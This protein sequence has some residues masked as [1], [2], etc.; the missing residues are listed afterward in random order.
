M[1]ATAKQLEPFAVP[2]GLRGTLFRLPLAELL[3]ALQGGS[4]TGIVALANGE[5]RKALYLKSGRVVF[6]TSN[7]PGDRLGDVLLRQGRITPEQHEASRRAIAHGRRQGRALVEA[8]ALTPDELWAAVQ[9]QVR[10]I[11][12]SVFEWD[13]GSFHFEESVLPERERITVDL[14]VTVLVLEGIRR[15]HPSPALRSRYPDPQLV[16]ERAAAPPSGVLH[17][18]EDH[19]L[20]LVDGERSVFEVCHESDAGE[21]ATLKAL[22]AMRCAGLVRARGRKVRPLDQ[23][24]V[25]ADSALALLDSFNRMYRVVLA[26]MVREVGPIAENV[27]AKYL[28]TLRESRPEVLA[29]VSLRKDGSLDEGAVERNLARLSEDRRRPA[30]VDALNEL[31]YAE[32]LAVKRTLGVEH[33][34]AIVRELRSSS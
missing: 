28:N 7:Q 10:E 21:A 23:D 5:A 31:L 3:R 14:D 11:V 34:G 22:Y 4:S 20:S 29:G 18:W 32:L 25:P 33:E 2:G 30:L 16:L 27:L 24:F 12:F 13:E 1:S 9:S 26:Y 8:G 6:A 19:V 15:S 17:P